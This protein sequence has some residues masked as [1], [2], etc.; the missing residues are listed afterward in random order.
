M[1]RNHV[2][3]VIKS[4]W[5]KTR[6]TPVQL[7]TMLLVPMISVLF[8]SW[9]LS[10]VVTLV[11]RYS[12]AVYFPEDISAE[13]MKEELSESYPDFS[14]RNGTLEEATTRVSNGKADCALVVEDKTI[15][16]LY[17]S[18]ILTSS[19][20][21]K[22]AK[23]LGIDLSYLLEG[24]KYYSDAY[25]FYPEIESIDMSSSADRLIGY[26]DRVGGVVGMIIFLMMAS[27]AMTLS[28]RTITGEKERQTFDTLVL[29]PAELSKI[30]LGKEL[31]M[32]AEIFL[33]GIIGAVAAVV[34]MAIW[35][36]KEFEAVTENGAEVAGWFFVIVLLI[37][38]AALV[39]T[40]IFSIIGSAF[41]QTKKT[42][43]FS[44]CGMVLVSISAILP[45]FIDTGIVEYF[46]LSNWTPILK[47]ICKDEFTYTPIFTALAIS[48]L[49]FG[50][51]M[52]LS[53]G[54][55]ERTSE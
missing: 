42:S 34:G 39:I 5:K 51:S 33:S 55:W 25:A 31:V 38:A 29:C 35:S 24:E 45:S 11:D 23:D 40:A 37:F 19:Q 46:P 20:A 50:L 15:R 48:L 10:Y 17:D 18:S 32:L 1:R 27:N 2:L 14:F 41:A 13:E 49:L 54:L 43:L 6:K 21:L 30:L 26:I 16:I 12:G 52:I 44:S 22:D 28:A 53:S 7:V 9:C 36:P 3:H 4:E 47:S 8:L